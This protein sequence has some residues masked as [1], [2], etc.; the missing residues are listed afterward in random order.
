MPRF[1][2]DVSLNGVC[3]EP[4]DSGLVLPDMAA[5]QREALVAAA[6]ILREAVLEDNRRQLAI[7]IR[8]GKEVLSVVRVNV[9]LERV[10]EGQRADMAF[11][12]Q[13]RRP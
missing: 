13:N 6:D 9:S 12:L 11:V 10:G 1:F 3:E 2:F 5:A 7:Q 8:R 4:D